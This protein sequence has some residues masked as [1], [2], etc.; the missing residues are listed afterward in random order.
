[1]FFHSG[2]WTAKGETEAII[3]IGFYRSTDVKTGE[4][5]GIHEGSEERKVDKI[6]Y[7]SVRFQ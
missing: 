1:M 5:E 4:L 3:I 2:F 6:Q 7:S